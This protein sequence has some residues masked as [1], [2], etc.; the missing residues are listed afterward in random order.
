MWTVKSSS[1][2]LGW[3]CLHLTF[4]MDPRCG[5]NGRKS[6]SRCCCTMSGEKIHRNPTKVLPPLF[7]RRVRIFLG[8]WTS[9][10]TFVTLQKM[11]THSSKQR[12]CSWFMQDVSRFGKRLE[13]L[14][15]SWFVC[16]GVLH[17]C[18]PRIPNRA[19]NHQFTISWLH[20]IANFS[21]RQGALRQASQGRTSSGYSGGK[22]WNRRLRQIL[23]PLN[24]WNQVLNDDM[25][26]H[27]WR[28]LDMFVAMFR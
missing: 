28:I 19:P 8:N 14:V 16:C 25:W 18:T 6:V 10:K 27:K 20:W 15:S 22:G 9:E 11:A 17:R 4:A 7:R 24:F 2:I 21:A 13:L 1:F 26:H 12:G 3:Y 5:E 23:P